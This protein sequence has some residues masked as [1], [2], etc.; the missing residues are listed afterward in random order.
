MKRKVYRISLVID[1]WCWGIGIGNGPLR[2]IVGP[3]KLVIGTLLLN[4]GDI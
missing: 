2:L 1:P 3:F 4:E